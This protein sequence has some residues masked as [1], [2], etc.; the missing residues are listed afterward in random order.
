V[1]VIHRVVVVSFGHFFM[2]DSK[3]KKNRAEW[4]DVVASAKLAARSGNT[5][6]MERLGIEI[7]QG[8]W[9]RW[10]Y[11]QH[12]YWPA[13]HLDTIERIDARTVSVEEFQ[14]LYEYPHVP[15][16]L[17]HAILDWNANM[18]WS[19]DGM[20][21]YGHCQF[22]VG[23]DDQGHAVRIKWKHYS[24]YLQSVHGAA[25]D[26][27]PLY[28][29][30]PSF[31]P[32]RKPKYADKPSKQH[33]LH[34]YHV[35]RH[36]G[37]DVFAVGGEKRRPLYRWLV[38]G[39]ERSG[40]GI[41]ID[42][43]GTSA[44][45][46]LVRGHKRW[47]LFPPGTPKHVWSP[48]K[49]WE[50]VS[51]FTHVRPKMDDMYGK[52]MTIGAFYGMREI[53]QQPGEVVFVPSGWAHVVINLDLTFAVTQNYCSLANLNVCWRRTQYSRPVF[54]K[55]V[56]RELMRRAGSECAYRRECRQVLQR[57]QALRDEPDLESESSSSSES[58]ST[59][60]SEV[61]SVYVCSCIECR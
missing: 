40:T 11:Q 46:A 51:W 20:K 2:R 52:G 47:V 12:N 31:L 1:V 32:S 26:D 23:E 15:V 24:K 34:D 8:D 48:T 60:L 3:A 57:I 49:D 25:R 16:V 44:W 45:N 53:L 38:I 5:P 22:K 33:L 35:P 28:V 29:F 14:Q 50:G 43:L 56:E 36:F 55:K 10:G 30:E 54:A 4:K 39:P 61:E 59:A 37:Q 21:E 58:T 27:S 17:T 9:Y 13:V 7:G 18:V 6:F 19:L 41:H 42:P